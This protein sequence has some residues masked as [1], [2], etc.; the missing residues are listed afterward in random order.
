VVIWLSKTIIGN[1]D[2]SIGICVIIEV[3]GWL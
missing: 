3:C 2:D 1:V